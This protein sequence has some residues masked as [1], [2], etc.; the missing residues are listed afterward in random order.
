MLGLS[1]PATAVKGELCTSL[2]SSS[3]I[4]PLT[5]RPL[6]SRV[7]PTL[8]VCALFSLIISCKNAD[9]GL[10]LLRDSQGESMTVVS[11]GLLRD[12]I[13]SGSS[14]YINQIGGLLG[15]G[16]FDGVVLNPTRP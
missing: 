10:E 14:M 15:A 1:L 2:L 6:T 4:G 13:C 12:G 9:V 8:C 5:V 7:L 16:V 11:S 3:C